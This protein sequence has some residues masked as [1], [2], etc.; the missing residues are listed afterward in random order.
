MKQIFL[1]IILSLGIFTAKAQNRYIAQNVK[2]K[3][4]IREIE[5]QKSGKSE[6]GLYDWLA[7]SNAIWQYTIINGGYFTIGTYKGLSE[8]IIDDECS[9]TFGHPFAMS[10][11]AFPVINNHQYSPL[12]MLVNPSGILIKN[13]GELK[14]TVNIDDICEAEFILTNLEPQKLRLTYRLRNISAVVQSFGMGL[15]Y[16]AACG[17]GDDGSIIY[18]DQFLS[19]YMQVSENIQDSLVFWERNQ[20][21]KGIGFCMHYTDN[22]PD[23]ITIGNWQNLYYSQENINKLFDLA[24]LKRWNEEPVQPNETIEFTI[25]FNLLVPD[26]NGQPFLR[27][28]MPQALSVENQILFPMEIN[29]TA[30]IVTDNKNFSGLKLY[31]PE[32]YNISENYSE[33]FGINNNDTL[34]YKTFQINLSE[35]YDSIVLEVEFKLMQEE[36]TIDR[37][38]QHVF[39]PSSPFSYEGI[40]VDAD[41]VFAHNDSISL[42]FNAVRDETGQNIYGLKNP[43][44]FFYDEQSRIYDYILKKDTTGGTNNADIVFVLDVTGSMGGEIEGVKDNILEFAD[45][46][47]QNRINYRLGMVTF[48]DEIENIYNFTD[49]IDVFYSYVAQQYAHGGSDEPENS[50]EALMIATQFDFRPISTRTIIWITDATYHINNTICPYVVQDVID[51]LLMQG[52]S[53]YCAGPT[54]NY[55]NWYEQIV[56]NTGGA[57][58]DIYGNIRDILMEVAKTDENPNYILSYT[59]AELITAP[60]IYTVEVHYAGLGGT[61]TIVY[62]PNKIN[63]SEAGSPAFETTDI[64]LYP[65]PIADQ[66]TYLRISDK[67]ARNGV[68]EL[69]EINGNKLYQGSYNIENGIIELGKNLSGFPEIRTFVL[70]LTVY[71][72]NNNCYQRSFKLLNN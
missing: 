7:G 60:V 32:N 70:K 9:I 25:D 6:N 24:I 37:I 20:I 45:S 67:N 44:V 64:R 27:W 10:S 57:F 38:V 23:E 17:K 14:Y 53:V 3:Y 12:E 1:I 33:S 58:F 55:T 61:D 19:D 5:S 40:T 26:Y 29:T 42:R 66:K 16:D 11:Y 35:I 39:I 59:P 69:Y 43:N 50:L 31:T 36:N 63:E 62:V 34:L 13:G 48:K 54:Y 49:N 47:T 15:M 56:L 65:N 21:P 72:A 51:A 4:D 30:Q 41:T 8:S 22:K 71:D 18:N 68:V 46:L 2:N 52:I 28:D